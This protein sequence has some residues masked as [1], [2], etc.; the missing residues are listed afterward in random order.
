MH[1]D[2]IIRIK[3][4]T[5]NFLLNLQ[6]VRSVTVVAMELGLRL[7]NPAKQLN[8]KFSLLLEQA[9]ADTSLPDFEYA[10]KAASSK[11]NC[12]SLNPVTYCLKASSLQQRFERQQHIE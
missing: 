9:S 6:T 1:Q 3:C 4:Q 10:A 8:F 5:L 2:N 7:K 11:L 12:A